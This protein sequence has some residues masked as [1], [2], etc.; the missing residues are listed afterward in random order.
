MADTKIED[1]TADAS[2]TSDDLLVTVNDPAGTPSNRKV[3]LANAIT[4]AHGLSDGLV[5]VST[6]IMT[7]VPATTASITASTDKNYVTDAQAI[8]IGNTSGTNT[9]DNATNTQY[10]GL[11]AS[12]QDVIT[13]LPIA[14]GG[15][16]NSSALTAGSVLFSD[17]SAVTQDNANLFFNNTSKRLGV[18][19]NPTTY[20]LEVSGAVA[21]YVTNANARF[22]AVSPSAN[23]PRA[24]FV[25]GNTG[26]DANVGLTIAPQADNKAVF[27]EISTYQNVLNAS[28][29][30]TI[31]YQATTYAAVCTLTA[32]SSNGTSLQFSTRNFNG[33]APGLFIEAETAQRI[34][35]GGNNSSPLAQLHI[36]STTEQ[37]RVGYDGSNYYSTTVGSTGAVTFNAI[38]AGSAFTF[39]DAVTVTSLT[40]SSLTSGRVTFAGASGVLQDDADFTFSVDTLTVTKIAATTFTGKVTLS[41]PI[42]LMGYTV[43]GLPAG[44]IGEVAYVTDALAPAFLTAVVGGG[45]IVAPV[46]YN[47]TNWVAY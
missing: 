46:F 17:G 42:N 6:G 16:N 23:Y 25:I 22:T 15:T 37:L 14:N 35:I 12:K 9:G 41:N 40:N 36:I 43:A 10:S 19:R 45:A 20:P 5:K 21:S 31:L 32:D 2:P 7:V 8:V 11:A 30:Q 3:T 29:K 39:S 28:A 18:A 1:L 33:S 24:Q 4:K 13:V 44:V 38:G 47:G 34:A 27:I 26:S